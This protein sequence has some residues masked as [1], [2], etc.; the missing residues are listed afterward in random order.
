MKPLVVVDAPKR[1]PLDIPGAEVVSS[2]RYLSDPE[3]AQGPGRKVFNLCRSLR[4]QTAG[5]YV[6]L[7]AE[8]RSPLGG[9]GPRR[10]PTR[11]A[12][13]RGTG[14]TRSGAS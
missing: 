3:L 4:Y 11:R 8:A 13:A 1:W 14:R 10:A 7:L 6:S 9:A 12:Q 2:F 5:Y